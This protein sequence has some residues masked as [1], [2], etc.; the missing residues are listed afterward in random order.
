MLILL[1]RTYDKKQE[2]LPRE[3]RVSAKQ[4]PFLLH[5]SSLLSRQSVS[6]LSLSCV[7]MAPLRVID[8]TISF[9]PKH[10]RQHV[11]TVVVVVQQ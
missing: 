9:V 7:V 1:L 10:A 11:R 2:T 5:S 3:N 4:N 6:T 8:S